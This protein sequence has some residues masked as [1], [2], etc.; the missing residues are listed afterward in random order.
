MKASPVPLRVSFNPWPWSLLAFFAVL[1]TAIASF[2]VF[3]LRQDQELVRPDY[4]EAELRH[5]AQ[6]ERVRRTR[7]LGDRVSL[8]ERDRVLVLSLPAEH[9][10]R[11]MTGTL[12]LYRPS[13]SR[14]DREL[15]LSPAPTGRQEFDLRSLRPGLWK[16]AVLWSV[17]GWE[18]Y[19]ESTL[20]LP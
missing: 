16:A 4:Y 17:D 3:A 12:R 6:I 14:L 2:V 18:Y 7:A 10:G 5:Q 1:L 13:D 20:V 8:T 11:G 9:S 19:R 15:P